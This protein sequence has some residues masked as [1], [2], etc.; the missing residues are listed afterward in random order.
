LFLRPNSELLLLCVG[1]ASCLRLSASVVDTVKLTRW[2]CQN[3]KTC[4]ICRASRDRAKHKPAVC[5]ACY[6]PAWL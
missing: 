6:C 2:Q 5:T 4:T 1:H 3:C